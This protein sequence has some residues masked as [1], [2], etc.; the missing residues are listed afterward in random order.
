M[1]TLVF[2][3]RDPKGGAYSLSKQ[4]RTMAKNYQIIDSYH[5]PK[6]K[7]E[8]LQLD[9]SKHSDHFA[10]QRLQQVR[11]K[12]N[13][14]TVVTETGALRLIQGQIS[15]KNNGIIK[16]MIRKAIKPTYEGQGEIY[17]EPSARH[18]MLHKLEEEEIIIDDDL[19]LCCDSSLEVSTTRLPSSSTLLTKLKGT[20]VCVLQ[21]PVP[22]NKI[23]KFELFNERLQIDQNCVILRS[24]TLTSSLDLTFKNFLQPLNF[25]NRSKCLQTFNGTGKLWIAPIRLLN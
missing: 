8:I 13:N 12:L 14:G 9:Q 21:S 7:F 25:F 15:A 23:L 18:Y 10:Q 4:I 24:G 20:G 17:L 11:V 19:F 3:H 2:G 6:A 16:K 5:S 1:P 22:E